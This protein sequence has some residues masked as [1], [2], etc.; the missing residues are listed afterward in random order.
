MEVDAV[1]QDWARF[2]RQA[3]HFHLKNAQAWADRATG[4]DLGAQ[5]DPDFVMGPEAFAAQS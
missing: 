1:P 3:V 5:V 4:V 2:T